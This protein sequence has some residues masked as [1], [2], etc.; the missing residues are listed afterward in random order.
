MF[1]HAHSIWKGVSFTLQ[2]ATHS[3]KN[4]RCFFPSYIETIPFWRKINNCQSHL[5]RAI[6][7]SYG[8]KKK[9]PLFSVWI[10]F[11]VLYEEKM[12]LIFFCEHSVDTD[13]IFV[14]V[15]SLCGAI[16]LNC[17][18]ALFGFENYYFWYVYMILS[19]LFFDIVPFWFFLVLFIFFMYILLPFRSNSLECILI[20][21]MKSVW[22]GW[23]WI[24]NTR[25]ASNCDG[26]D[27]GK[28]HWN[29]S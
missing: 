26:N 22:S 21:N 19:G 20:A 8:K 15:W 17:C 23:E 9:I 2:H 27:A 11:D 24:Y 10:V 25:W 14:Q 18:V 4:K 3:Q 12:R 7:S 16:I 29:A 1:V 6:F 13:Q 5:Y 28:C